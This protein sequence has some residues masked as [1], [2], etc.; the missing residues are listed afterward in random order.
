[1][2]LKKRKWLKALAY[3]LLAEDKTNDGPDYIKR[4][5]TML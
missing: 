2:A 4:S 3:I 1:V 5:I